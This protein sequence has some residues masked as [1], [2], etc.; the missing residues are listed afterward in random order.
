M[1]LSD[2]LVSCVEMMSSMNKLSELNNQRSLVMIVQ[3]LP[4]YLQQRWKREAH[5]I[6]KR[7]GK[8]CIQDVVSFI[9][10]AAE[11]VNDP[12]FG[13]LMLVQPDKSQHTY[14]KAR[15]DKRTIGGNRQQFISSNVQCDE[16]VEQSSCANYHKTVKCDNI[17]APKCNYYI[18]NTFTKNTY[19]MSQ[20][21]QHETNTTQLQYYE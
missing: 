12:V 14:A 19:F 20:N 6:T 3:R 13:N 21:N 10:D 17:P 18:G 1:D 11:E 8:A 7:N 16:R 4:P 9:S 2:E 15:L 5:K